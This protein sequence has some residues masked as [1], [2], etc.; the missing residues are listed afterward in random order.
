MISLYTKHSPNHRINCLVS[1][2]FTSL[3]TSIFILFPFDALHARC[4]K[5][6]AAGLTQALIAQSNYYQQAG[7]SE[8]AYL[9]NELI[10]I[11]A[12][13]QEFLLSI[14]ENNPAEVIRLAVPTSI[15]AALPPAV[16]AYIEQEVEI[17]GALEVIDED[18]EQYS[19]L[20]YYLETAGERLSLHFA[21]HRPE[22]LLTG[23][24]IR[25]K[26]VQIDN[27]LALA[28]GGRNLKPVV[29]APV[30]STLGEQ[31]TLLILVNFQ[32]N[33]IEPY[34]IVD[35]ESA[36]FGETSD[37]FLE[38]SSLQTWLNGDVLG[39]YTI[40][41]ASSVCDI[42][43]IADEAKSAAAA[44]GV[45]LSAYTH[46]VYAF[47]KNGCGGL[48][49]S[50]VGGN[51]SQ[52]WIIGALDLSVIVHE[53][54][55]ALGTWHSHSLDCGTVTL[56]PACTVFEYG[57]FF[58][59]MGNKY[60]GHYNTFH[61]ER[62]GWLNTEASPPITTVLTDG[63]Y[64]LATY[65]D[66]GAAPKALKI[67]KS[68]D[69]ST[70]KRTWYYVESRQAIGFDAFLADY[71]NVLNGVLISIGSESDGNSSY[72]L[73]MTPDSGILNVYDWSDPALI[74]GQSFQDPDSGVTITTEWLTATE[75]AVYVQVGSKPSPT[76]EP[77]VTVFTDQPT[78]TLTQSVFIQAT[79]LFGGAPVANTPV[80]FKVKKSTG[81]VVMGKA[82]T[83]ING[84]AVY[85][86]RLM[87]KD[88]VGTYTAD[89]AA[90]SAV[91]STEFTVQ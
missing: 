38:N 87:R 50:T 57:H 10:E 43:A 85:K 79:V 51:P 55:H 37:F 7:R 11:A 24:K 49:L 1:P 32:D 72:L 67:L 45:N 36:L 13:R 52:T 84:T 33:P 90:L 71:P 35:A 66:I 23:A 48:G 40:P 91:D 34:T 47:P 88:P 26:G 4:A 70:G 53:L 54:G 77:A 82:T 75:A 16:Q 58:D 59:A 89:A 31:R 3:L 80:N 18:Y 41:V 5:P 29:P 39:W 28:G 56:G 9:L 15:R 2:F 12:S 6:D 22:Y 25:V 60:P 83:G 17:E 19:R 65:E 81:A 21:D 62:L 14:I 86:F 30:P 64:T 8:Q 27:T 20:L 73:D 69:P 74:E 68:T 78:Y 46:Y 61:K 44:A 76:N 63:I 42:Y